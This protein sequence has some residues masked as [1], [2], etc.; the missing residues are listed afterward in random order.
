MLAYAKRSLIRSD[1]GDLAGALDDQ[2]RVIELGSPSVADLLRR[3]ALRR[4]TKDL[5]GADQDLTKA[6]KLAPTNPQAYFQR[7]LVR[8]DQKRWDEAIADNTRAIDLKVPNVA[9]AYNNRGLAY[10]NSGKL[11][12]ARRDYEQALKIQPGEQGD[13][14]QPRQPRQVVRRRAPR[15]VHQRPNPRSRPCPVPQYPSLRWPRRPR[16]RFGQRR[17]VRRSQSRRMRRRLNLAPSPDPVAT[18]VGLD[19][20]ATALAM[21]GMRQLAGPLSPADEK[22]FNQKWQPF[23]D[24]PTPE[25]DAYFQ[26]LGPTLTE[27][28]AV[29]GVVARSAAS[30]DYA[31]TDAVVALAAGDKTGAAESLEVA[32]SHARRIQSANARLNRI[33]ADVQRL[34]NPPNPVEAKKKASQRFLKYFVSNELPHFAYLFRIEQRGAANIDERIAASMNWY[35][36]NPGRTKA[37]DRRP[38]SQRCGHIRGAY[39]PGK[40][41]PADNFK[42]SWPSEDPFGRSGSAVESR[43]PNRWTAPC[44]RKTWRL[45]LLPCG[46]G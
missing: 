44:H 13:R 16:I 19:S 15:R 5:A 46:T 11:A 17:P 3:A 29:Q 24:F 37:R 12:E 14:R 10:K 43:G 8:L 6:I 38:P 41:E 25:S 31:W 4:S 27:L 45:R 23:F 1:A 28:T 39:D 2:N 34:G 32:S 33:S 36:K 40:P 35:A 26:K 9:G 30:L 20:G 18:A 21:E 42:P 7:G 22:T